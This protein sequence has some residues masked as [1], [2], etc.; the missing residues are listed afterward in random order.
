MNKKILKT[1]QRIEEIKKELQQ[2][3]PMRPGK[4][5][6]QKRKDKNGNYYG[7]YW[8]ISFTHQGQ[9]HSYYIP[10]SLVEAVEKQTSEYQR[11]KK[12]IDEWVEKEIIVNQFF[13]EE[14]KKKLKN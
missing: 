12:L 5:S 4:L 8:Q 14:D 11:F 2:I 13:L 9:S 10:D 1:Q 3:G 6:P 7:E